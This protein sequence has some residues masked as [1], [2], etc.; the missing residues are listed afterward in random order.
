M[1]GRGEKLKIWEIPFEERTKDISCYFNALK[2]SI[3][4]QGSYAET[5]RIMKMLLGDILRLK[6][7]EQHE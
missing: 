4:Q 5:E 3:W 1:S 7:S 6:T 2:T